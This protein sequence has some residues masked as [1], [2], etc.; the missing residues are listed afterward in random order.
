MYVVTHT[1]A[2]HTCTHLPCLPPAVLANELRKRLDALLDAKIGEPRLDIASSP[3]V[4]AIIRLCNTDG[5]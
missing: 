5:L 3:V 2:K 4:E 1:N